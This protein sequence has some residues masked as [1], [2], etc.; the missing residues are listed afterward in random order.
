MQQASLATHPFLRRLDSI[1]TFEDVRVMAP[2]FTFF[3]LCFQDMLRLVHE[4]VRHPTIKA[5][6]EVHELEDKGH[7]KW[8]LHDLKQ[9][10][11]PLDLSWVFGS[12]HQ[13]TRDLSYDIVSAVLR[14]ADD[15]TRLAIVLSL[16]GAG[17]EFFGRVIGC[18]ERIGHDDGL[19]YFARHHQEIEENH[20]LF[21]SDGRAQLI[22]LALSRAEFDH[23]MEA[24][25]HTFAAMTRLA[26]H[27]EGAITATPVA[28]RRNAPP[29]A[30]ADKRRR[31]K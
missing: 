30:S 1:G 21:D 14:A 16:E 24:V 22:D 26:T 31:A 7:Q 6:A 13:A 8:F 5:M 19:K 3:V 27:L 4:H 11:I 12:D 17:H 28:R 15:H 29:V 23:A 20:N 10:G 9:F 2:R 25:D 18:L